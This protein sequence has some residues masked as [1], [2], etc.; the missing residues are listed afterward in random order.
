MISI[1]RAT[2]DDIPLM[3][4]ANLTCLPENYQLKYYL[5]HILSWPELSY[6]A[7]DDK[8]RVV[9]YVLAKME[10]DEDEKEKQGHI[11]SLAVMKS[12]RKLGLATLLMNQ[13]EKSLIENYGAEFLCLHVRR[14]NRAALHLYKETLGFKQENIE[15]GYYADGEDALSM[16][17]KLNKNI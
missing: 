17:K 14:S 8:G 13:A 5:Y 16:K 10:D 7:H 9:G 4:N 15:V 6:I 11:T 1:R 12:H 2:T 3:Q